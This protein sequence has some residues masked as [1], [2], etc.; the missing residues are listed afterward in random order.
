[1]KPIKRYPKKGLVVDIDG[2]WWLLESPNDFLKAVL[3]MKR[4][5]NF[6]KDGKLHR[7]DGPAVVWIDG[8]K[9]WYLKGERHRTDG[10]AIIEADGSKFWCLNG[11][12]HR[13]DGP[14]IIWADGSEEWYFKDKLLAILEQ[15]SGAS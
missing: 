8:Y 7:E 1:M 4:Y 13:E 5:I 15:C 10:P 2:Q 9:A 3:L 11:K 14:A 12:R 6:Y